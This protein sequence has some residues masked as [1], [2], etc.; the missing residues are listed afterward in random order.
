MYYDMYMEVYKVRTNI[1]I[2]DAIMQ[3]A[4]EISRIKTKREVVERALQEFV[5]IHSRKDLLDLC[6]KI[7]FADN[8]DYKALREGR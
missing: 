2:D 7:R 8:Y 6:G 1:V 3:R 4:I 5:A